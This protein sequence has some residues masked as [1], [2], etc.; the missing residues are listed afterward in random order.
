ME[1]K[2][3]ENTLLV[4]TTENKYLGINLIKD[5]QTSKVTCTHTPIF[6]CRTYIC[7]CIGT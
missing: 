4:M 1:N 6:M 3:Y 2:I 7:V 5:M